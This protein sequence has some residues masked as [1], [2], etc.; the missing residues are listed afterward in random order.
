MQGIGQALCERV[1]YDADS[2]QALT[3]TFMHYALLRVDSFRDFKTQFD[4]SVPCLT[5]AL[6]AK[7]IGELGTSAPRRRSS[8]MRSSMRL[9]MPAASGATPSA[10]RCR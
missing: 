9:P 6:G 8:S 4:T 5:N 3:A 1:V 2:G 7:G 10:C